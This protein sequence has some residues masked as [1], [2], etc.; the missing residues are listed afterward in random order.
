MSHE[1][2]RYR[3]LPQSYLNVRRRDTHT[4]KFRIMKI[5]RYQWIWEELYRVSLQDDH[6]RWNITNAD[7]LNWRRSRMG[8]ACTLLMKWKSDRRRGFLKPAPKRRSI[9]EMRTGCIIWQCTRVLWISIRRSVC[10]I[11]ISNT[12]NDRLFVAI[13]STVEVSWGFCS[14]EPPQNQRK[15]R[16]STAKTKPEIQ[17]DSRNTIAEME[18]IGLGS[19]KASG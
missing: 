19:R 10:T 6:P 13:R 5:I 3:L 8:S 15:A 11:S 7:T 16:I 4:L 1:W 17:F 9:M 18:H 14:S 2:C 12:L